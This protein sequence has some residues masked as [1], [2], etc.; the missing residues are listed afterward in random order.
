MEGYLITLQAPSYIPFMEYSER[1]DLRQKIYHAYMSKSY[2]DNQSNNLSNIK[3]ILTLRREIANLLGYG[4]YAE[5][6]LEERMAGTEDT[7]MD[8]LEDLLSRCKRFA[9]QEFEQVRGIQADLN[10]KEARFERW[11]WAYYAEKLRKK[12][13]DFDDEILKPYFQLERVLNG[14]FDTAGIL[15]DLKFV[16]NFIL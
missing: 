15:Y 9:R 7:V 14:I 13:Y 11:D 6:V 2:K 8:F 4:S 10:P 5:Y 1:R 3:K 16:A 12:R